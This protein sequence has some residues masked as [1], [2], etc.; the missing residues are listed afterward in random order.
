MNPRVSAA[1]V[2]REQSPEYADVTP[3]ELVPSMS[4]AMRC[5][6][7]PRDALPFIP[8]HDVWVRHLHRNAPI[9][10]SLHCDAPVT[11]PVPIC[12]V[13]FHAPACVIV[14]NPLAS[15]SEACPI[16]G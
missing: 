11:S 4:G 7:M 14:F 16:I 1:R 10:L 15:I 8:S 13:K 12:P 3:S 9:R 5:L 6:V 2:M